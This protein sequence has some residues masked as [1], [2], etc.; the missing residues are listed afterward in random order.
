[1]PCLSL[2]L[3]DLERVGRLIKVKDLE[4][5]V[6]IKNRVDGESC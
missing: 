2:S 6:E 1:M 5:I 4:I 3:S